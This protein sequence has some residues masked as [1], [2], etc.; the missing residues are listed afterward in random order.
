MKLSITEATIE[1]EDDDIERIATAVAEKIGG[2]KETEDADEPNADEPADDDDDLA[3]PAT[4]NKKGP[5][6]DE[7]QDAITKAAKLNKPE[8]KKLLAK[9]GVERGSELP[10]EKYPKFLE[11][12]GKIKKA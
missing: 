12:L 9:F 2:V 8:V 6:L 1:L 7:V 5:T 10:A 11:G 3:G 4:K